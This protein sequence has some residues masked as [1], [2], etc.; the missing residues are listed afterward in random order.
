MRRYLL[1]A[2]WPAGLAAITAATVIAARRAGTG[3]GRA[4]RRHTGQ[5]PPHRRD[6]GGG[7]VSRSHRR[8]RRGRA[9]CRHCQ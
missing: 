8:A 7:D 1:V 9:R 3:D 2:L 6:R 4:R 5:G